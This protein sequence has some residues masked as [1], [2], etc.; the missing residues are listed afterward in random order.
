MNN[1]KRALAYIAATLAAVSGS[2]A[3]LP[4][5]NQQVEGGLNGLHHIVVID[6]SLYRYEFL[7]GKSNPENAVPDVLTIHPRKSSI[8]N[9][10]ADSTVSVF[11]DADN[12]AQL[13]GPNDFYELRIGSEASATGSRIY[14]DSVFFIKNG[15]IIPGD[16]ISDS[17]VAKNV[18][19][20]KSYLAG[21]I[22]RGYQEFFMAM[23]QEEM[24][25]LSYLENF[26]DTGISWES[27]F[28]EFRART[29]GFGHTLRAQKNGVEIEIY[30]GPGH[31]NRYNLFKGHL[32][33][34]EIGGIFMTVETDQ[35]KK[36]VY[37][38]R[39]KVWH[40]FNN[41]PVT[42]KAGQSIM[43]DIVVGYANDILD[44]NAQNILVKAIVGMIKPVVKIIEDA[45]QEKETGKSN[46]KK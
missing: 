27:K 1:G 11:H 28:D 32:G 45:K 44:H 14:R 8:D 36:H 17:I 46:D 5:P 10:L 2:R 39:E 29:F 19:L 34:G 23:A 6:D 33:Y 41:I 16:G 30:D 43:G 25:R 40:D 15:K 38:D 31:F 24:S 3:Q 13:D 42:Y 22:S 12:N 7:D 18:S 9:V 37:A 35:G 4:E 26:D 21:K 20:L